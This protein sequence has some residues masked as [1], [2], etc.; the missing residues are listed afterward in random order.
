MHL[1]YF[2]LFP[3]VSSFLPSRFEKLLT[4][5]AV[6]SQGP[7]TLIIGKL[8]FSVRVLQSYSDLSGQTWGAFAQ[9]S[10]RDGAQTPALAC[11]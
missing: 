5:Q 3:A 1:G 11:S 7:R 4:A 2:L 6:V 8:A 10:S 9:R